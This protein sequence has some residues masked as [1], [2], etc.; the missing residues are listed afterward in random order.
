MSTPSEIKKMP[1]FLMGM[2]GIW[3]GPA[4]VLMSAFVGFCGF[5]YEAGI[6]FGEALFMTGMVWALPGQF[7]LIGAIV[8][9]ASLPAAA[10][11]VAL[12]SMRLMPM[13]ASLVPEIR[14]KDTPTWVLL[15]VSHFV[16]VTAW[17]FTMERVH[18]VP[19]EG[20]VAFFAGFGCA[21]TSANLM[22]VAVLYGV[23]SQLPAMIGGALFFLTPIYFITSIWA[24]ARGIEVYFAM[25]AGLLL[26]PLFH[27]ADAEL[28]ILYAG[29]VGGTLAFLLER[30][31][32]ARGKRKNAS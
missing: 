25:I 32:A 15:V 30:I 3:S 8:A 20:R 22:I 5:A 9:G 7:V 31:V 2:R 12:S 18:L 11:A 24:S 27:T 19:R 23:I 14:S 10:L 16:A 28:G 21:I 29:V 6:P 26:G 4:L 17:V 13:V 1:W